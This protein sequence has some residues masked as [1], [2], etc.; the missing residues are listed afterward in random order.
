MSINKVTSS[1]FDVPMEAPSTV[2]VPGK[3]I[4]KCYR[5]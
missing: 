3:D 2:T 4:Y 5:S 1:G